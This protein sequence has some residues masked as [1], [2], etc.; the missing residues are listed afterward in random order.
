MSV[1]LPRRA[2]IERLPLR[3]GQDGRVCDV[4]PPS[5]SRRPATCAKRVCSIELTDL[6]GCRRAAACGWHQAG[7]RRDVRRIRAKLGEHTARDVF[8]PCRPFDD[9]WRADGRDT[10]PL[11]LRREAE[12]R[13]LEHCLLARPCAQRRDRASSAIERHELTMLS[14][15]QH[16]G[17]RAPA[18]L[19]RLT[20]NGSKR[21]DVEADRVRGPQ[22]HA[23]E[24]ASV[25]Y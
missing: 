15:M 12:V 10:K 7:D 6:G 2:K 8:R 4:T 17:D 23:D 9:A 20:R 13:S 25:C 5:T 3:V 24:V 21:L 1:P 14:W 11:R 19:G 16:A 22:R 18:L